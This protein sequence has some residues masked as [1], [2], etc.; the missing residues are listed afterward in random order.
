MVLVHFAEGFEE[1]EAIATVDILRRA[2]IKTIMVS[3]TGSLTVNG[4][5]QIPIIT[6][7]LFEDALYHEAEMIVLPGGMPGTANLNLHAGLKN[8]I[9]TFAQNKKLAAV[10][11]APSIFG[12]MGLLKGKKAV[13]FPG[14]EDALQGATVLQIPTVTDGNI[15][16]GRGA[17]PALQF[18]LE[19]VKVLKG[20]DVATQL[21]KKM[22][23]Q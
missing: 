17:G 3:V 2:G 1:I 16:T 12:K 11:A 18:A 10:C 7:V 5:H 9:V 13:C 22:L 23:I 6:D 14:F 19:I 4:A 20:E 21:E 8:Q 15:T